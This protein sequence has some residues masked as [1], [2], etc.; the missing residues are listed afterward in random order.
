MRSRLGITISAKEADWLH[1][2][3]NLYIS[4]IVPYLKHCIWPTVLTATETIGIH[5]SN[6]CATL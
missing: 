3:S 5:D 2:A 1:R 4:G 6:T